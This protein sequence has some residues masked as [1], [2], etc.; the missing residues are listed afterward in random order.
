MSIT[1][2]LDGITQADMLSTLGL[3]EASHRGICVS[4]SNGGSVLTTGVIGYFVLPFAG[5][6]NKCILLS[7]VSGSVE[8]DI[9]KLG[10]ASFPPTVV[11]SIVGSS[12]PALVT[13]QSFIDTSLTGWS[14]S[15]SK[16]DVIAV[17]IR[18]ASVVK[19]I[20]LSLDILAS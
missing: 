17:N 14:K 19:Y 13:A 8:L 2:V 9:W 15:V 11:N 16:D 12:Y 7:D 20:S 5:T 10:A 18:S 1:N 6:I 3:V 4:A